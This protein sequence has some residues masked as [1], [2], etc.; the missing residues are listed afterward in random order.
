MNNNFSLSED[1]ELCM[2]CSLKSLKMTIFLVSIY[3]FHTMFTSE[4]C[5]QKNSII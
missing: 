1:S 5:M 3:T 2:K 4:Y